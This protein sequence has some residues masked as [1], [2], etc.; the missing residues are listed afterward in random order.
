MSLTDRPSTR[1]AGGDPLVTRCE[2]GSFVTKPAQPSSDPLVLRPECRSGIE[3]ELASSA[4]GGGI[5]FS[6][7]GQGKLA[8][9]VATQGIVSRLLNP[10]EDFPRRFDHS[11]GPFSGGLPKKITTGEDFASYFPR[12]VDGF[13]YKRVRIGFGDSYGRNHWHSKQDIRKVIESLRDKK[14]T[15]HDV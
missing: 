3:P 12:K 15:P 2:L 4:P 5:H 7:R 8:M 9:Q 10:L 6:S 1:S 11:I 14:H 13:Q